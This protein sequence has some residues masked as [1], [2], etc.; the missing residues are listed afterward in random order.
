[1]GRAIGGSL[2]MAVGIALS[3]FPVI[4]VVLMLAGRRA[5]VNAPAFV[6][7]WLIGRAGGAAVLAVNGAVGASRHGGPATWISWVRIAIGVLMLL[8]A[9]R[10]FRSRGDEPKM[11]KWM[12][13][14]D[15]ASPIA[16][17]GRAAVMPGA[18]PQD[19]L[20][21]VGGAA[22][23]A[24]TGI[25]VA[26]QAAACL[27]FALIGALGVG[28]PVIIYLALGARS[29][30]PLAGLKDWISAHHAAITIVLC[31]IIAAKH[32]GDA[33]SSLAG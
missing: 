27:V 30:E 8:V 22:A 6:L 9:V 24:Q 16:A 11:P 4:A 21:V 18:S 5:K 25:P 31:L 32:I 10:Q 3:P 12:A 17:L 13:I 28:I 2:P 20:L 15:K 29:Q 23:I 1:M 7:G 19:R 26:Q 33:I 14:I